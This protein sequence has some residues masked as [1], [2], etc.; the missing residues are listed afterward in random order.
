MKMAIS[1][2]F[3]YLSRHLIKNK[4]YG[5]LIWKNIKIAKKMPMNYDTYIYCF[6]IHY[7]NVFTMCFHEFWNF[8]F[9]SQNFSRFLIDLQ[10]RKSITM[11]D[12]STTD[13][14]WCFIIHLGLYLRRFLF[15][16]KLN[17][18]SISFLIN[19]FN[20]VWRSKR[21]ESSLWSERKTLLLDC[22]ELT[23]SLPHSGTQWLS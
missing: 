7:K 2:G 12:L 9:F 14:L 20:S 8:E 3:D 19:K 21:I 6:K 11:I 18:F 22:T 13:A 15:I 1:N 5:N 17:C 23:A 16:K 10:V 4:K